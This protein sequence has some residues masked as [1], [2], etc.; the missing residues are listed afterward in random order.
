MPSVI[1]GS[2]GFD[3]KVAKG[4]CFS[5][6]PS[7]HQSISSATWTKVQF[8]LEEFDLASD[9]DSVND[10]FQPSVAGYYTINVAINIGLS[11]RH[12]GQVAKN[13]VEEKR[14]FD[15]SGIS[16]TVNSGS[17]L[18]YMNGTTDYLEVYTWSDAGSPVIGGFRTETYFQG[19]LERSA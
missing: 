12:I 18:I 4:S 14:L 1:R 11:T 10:R 15:V 7:T 9:Y 17:A 8:D 6:Y 2:D 5:A 13:G 16:G 3:S 19:I